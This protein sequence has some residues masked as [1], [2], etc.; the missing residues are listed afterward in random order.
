MMEKKV[1]RILLIDENKR[2]FEIFQR[3]SDEIDEL[4]FDI[5]WVKNY[6]DGKKA[7]SIG[8]HDIIFVDND[9]RDKTGLQLIEY[10]VENE[11]PVPSILLTKK[12]Q[13]ELDRAALES[14]ATDYL[15]KE[16]LNRPI[17]FR[18]IRHAIQRHEQ[19][20]KYDYEQSKFRGFFDQSIDGV[21]ITDPT[22]NITAHNDS[23]K[24]MLGVVEE[25]AE[26][27]L[28]S[29]INLEEDWLKIE[30]HLKESGAIS[31]FPIKIK[32]NDAEREF[33]L[34]CKTILNSHDAVSGFQGVIRD[35]TTQ[36]RAERELAQAEQFN[37][38]GRMARILAHEIR[39]PLSNISL[40][41]DFLKD[42]QETDKETFETYMEIIVRNANRINDLIDDLLRSTKL[43]DL[44]M[45]PMRVDDVIH[46]AIEICE[47]RL[48]L[49]G[50]K[51]ETKIPKEHNPILGDF[52]KLTIALVNLITNAIEAM[53]GVESP[54]LH[55][56]C[57]KEPEYT[58]VFISDNGIGMDQETQAQL[59][60]PF[61]SKRHG[62]MGLGLSAVKHLISQHNGEIDFYSEL[63]EGT[64]FTITL[65][66]SS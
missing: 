60:R 3:I 19:K 22:G 42:A 62:G 27:S 8:G 40:A 17:L 39:N 52:E 34:S 18:T 26:L 47:D 55:I 46:S 58:I 1:I 43:S 66:H 23:L 5:D 61:Y 45:K 36:K 33:L 24:T 65:P 44:N 13:P 2:E 63:G 16:Y 4:D 7:I 64:T 30:A 37:L 12:D 56:E 14:G 29:I 28:R 32:R 10:I 20:L 50:V 53:N 38:T 59:F 41:S 15:A 21:F 25:G 31:D 54:E 57:R 49:K 11:H 48:Q 35:I 9:L 51:L 6:N